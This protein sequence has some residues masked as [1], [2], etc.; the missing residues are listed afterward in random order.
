MQNFERIGATKESCLNKVESVDEWNVRYENLAQK[1][2]HT[3]LPPNRNHTT[4]RRDWAHTVMKFMFLLKS[5]Y[6][7]FDLMK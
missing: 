1:R 7:R 5:F 6:V 2:Q 3:R 4:N